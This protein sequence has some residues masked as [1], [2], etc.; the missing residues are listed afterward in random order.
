MSD[1]FSGW[2]KP[3]NLGGI[4]TGEVL[5]EGEYNFTITDVKI[6][7]QDKEPKLLF[8][9]T[10]PSGQKAIDSIT[11]KTL[12]KF[13]SLCMAAGFPKDAKVFYPSLKGKR[14]KVTVKIWKGENR[15]FNN[16]K[17]HN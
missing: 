10:S 16:F 4:E 5:P 12:W 13:K 8:M 15:S 14:I 2:E 9:F 3:I 1:L 6:I 7:G 17:Y 11:E